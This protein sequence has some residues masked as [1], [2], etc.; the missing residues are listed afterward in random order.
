M[1][2][3]LPEAR[4]LAEQMHSELQGKCI[5]SY[6][7]QDHKKLQRWSQIG[8]LNKDIKD[9]NQL[10]GGEV[11]S[12]VSRGNV[13][14]VK[15]NND[16]N[17][18]LSPEYGGKIR[19]H[20]QKKTVPR[21]FNLKLTFSDDTVL[22]VRHPG[23][24]ALKKEDLKDCYVYRRDFNLNKPTPLD[25][26]FTL[27]RFSKL[28][29][30]ANRMLKSVLVGKDAVVVGL[31]NSAFQDVLYR[32]KL[33]PKRKASNLTE[34]EVEAL[35]DAIQLL[36]HERLRLKG[37]DRFFDLYGNQG[38]YAPVM[39]SNMK[40]Q[41]CPT[42]GTTIEKLSVGGGYVFLCPQCQV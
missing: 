25:D 35:Y 20:T 18:L 11:Y 37:K 27:A 15:L 2:I 41:A 34:S 29:A 10:V 6:Q 14:C 16:M 13:I 22:T 40:Q 21:D 12:V 5:A 36:I 33:H 19:Y 26:E 3:E 42:C 30:G 38:R 1:S 9:F 39:G 32:A 24:Y 23:I 17:L 7:L 28:L 4:I 31:S 8:F